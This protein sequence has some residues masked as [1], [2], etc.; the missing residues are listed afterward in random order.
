MADKERKLNLFDIVDLAKAGYKKKDIDEILKKAGEEK[1]DSEPEPSEQPPAENA[2]KDPAEGKEGSE[3][4][5]DDID[6]KK[7]YEDKC[8]ELEKAQKA[9]TQTNLKNDTD[10]NTPSIDDIVRS[11]M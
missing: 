2:E 8:A 4:K 1:S 9:N 5:K 3:D 11:F 10:D 6:Y 7:L